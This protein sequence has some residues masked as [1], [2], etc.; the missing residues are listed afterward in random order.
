MRTKLASLDVEQRHT[1]IAEFS[2]L[3]MKDGI[4]GETILF[5]NVRH[6]GSK[7][8]LTDH[9]WMNYCKAF[10]DV[11]FSSGDIIQFDGRLRAYYKGYLKNE[12]DVKIA[13]PT[14]VKVVKKS[15]Q[16]HRKYKDIE[17]V[18]MYIKGQPMASIKLGLTKEMLS[19]GL[20]SINYRGD[21]DQQLRLYDL[22]KN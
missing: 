16:N 20:V 8:V 12:I 10:Q 17:L 14:N 1:F 13:Y 9:L 19:K 6:K 18:K 11:P 2:R 22:Y 15:I 3:G 7:K 21:L 5:L 4:D